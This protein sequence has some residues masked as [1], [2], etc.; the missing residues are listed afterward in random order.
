MAA[1]ITLVATLCISPFAL[2]TRYVCWVDLKQVLFFKCS[3]SHFYFSYDDLMLYSKE[4]FDLVQAY[5]STVQV[6]SDIHTSDISTR[7]KTRARSMLGPNAIFM[8]DD[9][10]NNVLHLCVVHQLQEMYAHVKSVAE[11][12][13]NRELRVAFSDATRYKRRHLKIKAVFPKKL[14][15]SWYD[16]SL[17]TSLVAPFKVCYAINCLQF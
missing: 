10:G 6:E 7:Q 9:Y 14:K 13:I 16:T 8:C 2:T 15:M 1:T 12:F 11:S 3:I 5:A 4:I 17:P